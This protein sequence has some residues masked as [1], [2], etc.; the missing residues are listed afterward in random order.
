L[1]EQRRAGPTP[2]TTVGRLPERARYDRD[3][4][5]AILDEG[6][7]C[8]VG[9]VADGQP[10]VIPATYARWDD[11]LVI[12]GSAASRMVKALAGG[13][14]ACVSVTLLDGLVLARSAFHH[15][16]NYRSVVVVGTATEVV[17]PQE[18]LRALAAIVEHV[19][20]GRGASVRPP[21]EIELRA[22][23]VVTLPLDEASAKLRTGPPKDD[24]DDYAL[25][26]WAGEIP[27][28]LEPGPAVADPRLAPGIAVPPD[29]QLW[30]RPGRP[31]R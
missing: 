25:P 3:T 10:F 7:V 29:V 23:R 30:R 27:L 2:R 21:S 12:H 22:T 6:L 17:D 20:P 4:I 11:R 18:K 8:H 16:M 5:C 15:T 28:G 9:F 26:V 31:R 19:A 14:A 13:A 24:E 1:S